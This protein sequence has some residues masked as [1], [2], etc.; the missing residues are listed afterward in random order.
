MYK[1][2]RN[3]RIREIVLLQDG[4]KKKKVE[5][6]VFLDQAMIHYTAAQKQLLAA[7]ERLKNNADEA[8]MDEFLAAAKNLFVVLFGEKTTNEIIDF[9]DGQALEA[10]N[11]CTPFLVDRLIPR[12]NEYA[13]AQK[14]AQR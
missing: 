5:I 1:I 6:C 9:F 4:K 7:D 2:K 14:I 11:A 12:L 10:I 3:S 8:T 13:A